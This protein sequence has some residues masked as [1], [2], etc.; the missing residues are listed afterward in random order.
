MFH[1]QK[2]NVEY[3][4]FEITYCNLQA[5]VEQKHRYKNH[6]ITILSYSIVH[7]NVSQK[8]LKVNISILIFVTYPL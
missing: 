7:F 3:V 6:R 1:K 4:K 2:T 5:V 8:M